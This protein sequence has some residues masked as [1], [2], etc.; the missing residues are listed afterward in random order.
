MKTAL[1]I[2]VALALTATL[3]PYLRRDEWWIRAFDFPRLL[4]LA[5]GAGL[6][7]VAL[8]VVEP[9]SVSGAATLAA[10]VVI[11]V[12][13]GYEVL[14]YTPLHPKEV[15]DATT[16]QPERTLSL[17]VANVLMSNRGAGRLLDIVDAC[18][19]DVVLTLEPDEWWER[20][21]APLEERYPHVVRE[22]R[23]NRYGMILYSRHPLEEAS[24]RHIVRDDVPS[25]HARIRLPSGESC[26]L[27]ALHPEPPSPTEADDSTPRDAELL[28][29][30]REVAERDEPTI[31]AG[32]LNDV[33]WSRTTR[34]FQRISGLLDPRRGRGLI[35]TFHAGIPLVRWPLDHI[36]HSEHFTLDELARLPAFGSDHFPV[37]GRFVLE[38]HGPETQDEP[39]AS[40]EDERIA[41]EKIDAATGPD[42]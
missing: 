24:V 41:R 6:L 36:F 26:R 7:V 8:F 17:L 32:D 1:S 42:S 38:P 14:P 3:L 10:L 21:L 37:Y 34:L 4:I 29:V 9:R 15:R 2:L 13:Q 5:A 18:D 25:I 31:V 11:L 39:E 12:S 22:P 23:D 35:N 30:G 16:S 33:A 28:V 19:P 27:H 20:A 40:H